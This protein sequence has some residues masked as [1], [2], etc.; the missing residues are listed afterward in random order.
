MSSRTGARSTFGNT[1]SSVH[2]VKTP[3]GQPIPKRSAHRGRNSAVRTRG[4]SRSKPTPDPSL[5]G[6]DYTPNDP[7]AWPIEVPTSTAQLNLVSGN[8][9]AKA[10][11]NNN[12]VN[13]AF[14][15]GGYAG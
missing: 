15:R 7:L 13:K 2:T 12:V 6:M 11:W 3:W 8:S 4:S 1:R 9:A 5:R 10:T 14:Q